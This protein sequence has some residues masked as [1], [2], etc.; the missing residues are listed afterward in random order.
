[1]DALSLESQ[2]PVKTDLPSASKNVKER[3]LVMGEERGIA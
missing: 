2:S 3:D 1:L